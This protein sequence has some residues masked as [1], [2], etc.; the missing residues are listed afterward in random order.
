MVTE[1]DDF[2]GIIGNKVSIIYIRNK[3]MKTLFPPS[4]PA[5]IA[6]SVLSSETLAD[7]NID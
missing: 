4:T 5:L 6:L 7:A 3:K 2:L 1:R